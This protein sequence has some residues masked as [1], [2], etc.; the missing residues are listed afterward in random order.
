MAP[1]LFGQLLPGLRWLSGWKP[2]LVVLP[3]FLLSCRSPLSWISG[4]QSWFNRMAIWFHLKPALQPN[5]N[6]HGESV[7]N[8]FVSILFIFSGHE[9][10]SHNFSEN[11]S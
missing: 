9:N 1:C 10:E 4:N 11:S 6:I 2:S 3:M 8:Y 5:L 7:R